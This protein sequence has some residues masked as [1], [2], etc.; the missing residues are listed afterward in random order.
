MHEHR[1]LAIGDHLQEIGSELSKFKSIESPVLL[2]ASQT[3]Q[4]NDKQKQHAEQLACPLEVMRIRVLLA[5]R[6]HRSI[7]GFGIL[8]IFELLSS[9]IAFRL[10]QLREEHPLEER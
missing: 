9:N 7:E 3:H 1:L 5:Q 10:D 6:L 4:G 2:N 8:D